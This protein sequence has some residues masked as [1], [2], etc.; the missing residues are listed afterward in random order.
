[1]GFI[2]TRLCQNKYF[3]AWTIVGRIFSPKF[4]LVVITRKTIMLSY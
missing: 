4:F 3:T 1:M 2:Y